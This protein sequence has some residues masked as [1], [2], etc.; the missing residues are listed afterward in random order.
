MLSCPG[1]RL[2]LTLHLAAGGNCPGFYA[3]SSLRADSSSG[4]QEEHLFS[5]EYSSSGFLEGVSFYT[6]IFIFRYSRAVSFI[7]KYSS[8]GTQEEYPSS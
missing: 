2:T 5:Q 4:I 8:S 6:G 7:Q 1:D 3:Y